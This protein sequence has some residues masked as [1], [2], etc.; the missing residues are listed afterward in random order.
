MK[1]VSAFNPHERGL[2]RKRFF[3]VF[4]T[5]IVFILGVG[6]R[7][8]TPKAEAAPQA[9]NGLIILP[10]G[11]API[12]NHTTGLTDDLDL[13]TLA[14]DGAGLRRVTEG[15][16]ADYDPAWSPDGTKVAFSRALPYALAG[17]IY[18]MNRDGSELVNVT[19]TPL[20]DD[21]GPD[22]SPDGKRIVFTS[23]T[24]TASYV[25]NQFA[26]VGEFGA[27]V[28][29][30]D[31]DGGN[32]ARLVAGSGDQGL[33]AWSPDGNWIAFSDRSTGNIEL[34]RLNGTGRKTAA[35]PGR[36][37]GEAH[38]A[39]WSPDGSWISFTAGPQNNAD[40]WLVRPDGSGLRNLTRA[41]DTHDRWAAW[42]PDGTQMVF[43]SNRKRAWK[44]YRM[45][46]DGGNVRRLID[47][48][49]VG[50]QFSRPDWGPRP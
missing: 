7:Q 37:E 43:I 38:Q 14:P 46:S 5:G 10:V 4:A 9:Q 29:V 41:N 36:F 47:L 16:A 25:I 12:T 48:E 6:G 33:P 45:D 31:A 3:A 28:F 40:I 1:P 24:N 32:V 18:V 8:V 21:F 44:L 22:W 39:E 34:I 23:Y 50:A 15:P 11:T 42:S 35:A 17:D 20:D 26:P 13:F 27:D 30:M 49:L 19:N 2:A